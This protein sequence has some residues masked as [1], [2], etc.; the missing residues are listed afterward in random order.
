[1][2][3]RFVCG[4]AAAVACVAGQGHALPIAGTVNVRTISVDSQGPVQIDPGIANDFAYANAIYSQIGIRLVQQS[5]TQLILADPNADATWTSAEAS[6]NLLNQSRDNVNNPVHVY[7]VREFGGP[8]SFGQ[9]WS[10]EDVPGNAVATGVVTDRGRRND[11]VAHEVGH[12]LLDRWRWRAGETGDGGIHSNT[13]N[14]LM[15]NGDIRNIPNN[16][17]Q[18]FPTGTADQIGHNWGP[19]SNNAQRTQPQ[20]TAMYYNSGAVNITARDNVRTEVSGVQTAEHG[21]AITQNTVAG[22]HTWTSDQ[23]AQRVGVD[24]EKYTLYFRSDAA[25]AGGDGQRIFGVSDL[26]SIDTP[27]TEITGVMVRV[28]ADANVAG[29]GT[30]LTDITDFTWGAGFANQTATLSSLRVFINNSALAGIRDIHIMF[31]MKVVP[32]PGAVMTL[33]LAGLLA[34]RRRR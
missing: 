23:A 4:M 22:G 24:T 20:I 12:Y 25:L 6:Q 5:D 8:N 1:M 2:S 7:Y 28:F 14:D 17:N 13:G 9:A 33:G 11:T 27:F 10:N 26:Q 16:V 15:A 21:W 30:L 3:M 29:N 34:A 19:L 31:N 32:A 18:V